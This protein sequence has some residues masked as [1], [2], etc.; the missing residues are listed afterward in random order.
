M[1]TE[2]VRAEP[3]AVKLEHP[4]R[5]ERVARGKA[6]RGAV[7]RERQSELDLSARP[8]PIALIEEQMTGRI[9]ELIPVRYERM[10][11]SPFLFYRGAAVIMASDLSRTP[12]SGIGA[13]L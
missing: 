2:P 1:I 9:P 11:D 4:T 5:A 8:D 10:I 12:N 7:P 13:Q 6:A 3:R